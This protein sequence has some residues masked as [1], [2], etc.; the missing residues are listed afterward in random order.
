MKPQTRQNAQQPATPRLYHSLILMACVAVLTLSLL[1]RVAGDDVLF[2][3][4][5]NPMRCALAEFVGVK[6][7]FCGMTRAFSLAAHGD[8]AGSMHLHLLA[9]AM[10]AFICLQIPYR[11]TAIAVF[12]RRIPPTVTRAGWTAGA[13]IVASIFINWF[14]YLGGLAT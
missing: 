11:I 5:H 14:V 9:P 12:P 1:L 7:A 8:L 13:L 2:C 3:G 6:C 4:I 10:F